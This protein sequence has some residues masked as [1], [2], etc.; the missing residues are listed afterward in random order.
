MCCRMEKEPRVPEWREKGNRGRKKIR[1][2]AA[3]WVTCFDPHS[4]QVK[5]LLLFVSL[6]LI[7][8]EA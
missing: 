6:L 7:R 3:G 8:E 1:G 5:K 2:I 4:N